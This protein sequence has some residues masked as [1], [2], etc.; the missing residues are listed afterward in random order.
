MIRTPPSRSDSVTSTLPSRSGAASTA[1]F[2]TFVS[3]CFTRIPSTR[4]VHGT[5]GAETATETPLRPASS[6]S[7]KIAERVI[8]TRS[9]SSRCSAISRV[10]SSSSL[11]ITSIEETAS[12]IVPITSAASAP[13]SPSP[14]S[15]VLILIDPSGVR[16]SWATPAAICPREASF[17]LWIILFCIAFSSVRSL[18]EATKPA[19]PPPLAVIRAVEASPGAC[20]PSPRTM[21]TSPRQC[22]VR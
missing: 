21:S 22:P 18:N 14:S 13:P 15:R 3:T 6:S 9:Y 19:A 5:G 2:T 20:V 8:L 7:P 1:F 4:A 16:I 17:S 10:Y 12:R 11:T